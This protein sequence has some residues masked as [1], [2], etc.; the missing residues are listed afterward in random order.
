MF[1]VKVAVIVLFAVRLAIVQVAVPV[2]LPASVPPAVVQA[3][4]Q[5]TVELIPVA[6][7]TTA[8]PELIAVVVPELAAL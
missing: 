6:V 1:K 7:T 3:P 5:V 8:V 4:P 2:P